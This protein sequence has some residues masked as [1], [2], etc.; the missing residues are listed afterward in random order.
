[1]SH[2]CQTFNPSCW[3]CDLNLDE[4]EADTLRALI[5][6]LAVTAPAAGV[7]EPVA[8]DL[9]TLARIIGNYAESALPGLWLASYERFIAQAIIAAGFSRSAV[10][11]HGDES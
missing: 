11:E 5:R 10:P 9:D 6:G 4:L 2:T 3:R 8:D 1:M 7:A